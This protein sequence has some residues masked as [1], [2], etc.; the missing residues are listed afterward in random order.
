MT[1]LTHIY[2]GARK[3]RFN[4]V[5]GDGLRVVPLQWSMDSM[6]DEISFP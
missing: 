5:A 4:V 2:R 3:R 6:V 1:Q